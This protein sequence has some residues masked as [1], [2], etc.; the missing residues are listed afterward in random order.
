M[1]IN[2]TLNKRYYYVIMKMKKKKQDEII[3]SR[4]VNRECYYI[5]YQ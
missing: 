3:I 2:I 4:E 5:L 1:Y